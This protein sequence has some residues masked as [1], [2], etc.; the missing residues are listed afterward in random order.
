MS[1]GL[2]KTHVFKAGLKLLFVFVKVTHHVCQVARNVK[3]VY[4]SFFCAKQKLVSNKLA[5]P[6]YCKRCDNCMF[7]GVSFALQCLEQKLLQV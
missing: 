6:I 2:H 4:F 1:I 3:N 5:T 7:E